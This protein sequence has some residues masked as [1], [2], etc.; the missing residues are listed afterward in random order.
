MSLNDTKN[1]LAFVNNEKYIFNKNLSNNEIKSINENIKRDNILVRDNNINNNH[2]NNIIK[3]NLNPLSNINKD[4]DLKKENKFLF[5]SPKQNKSYKKKNICSSKQINKKE[6]NESNNNSLEDIIEDKIYDTE[7][8]FFNINNN[9]FIN[10]TN[11]NLIFNNCT[12][13]ENKNMD[14]KK[15][16]Q[17]KNNNKQMINKS[18][19]KK[20]ILNINTFVNNILNNK[21]N[22]IKDNKCIQKWKYISNSYYKKILIKSILKKLI[23]NKN[24]IIKRKNDKKNKNISHESNN[25]IVTT[26]IKPVIQNLHKIP[27]Y[28]DKD[29]DNY[30]IIDFINIIKFSK[31]NYFDYMEQ[32]SERYN[33]ENDKNEKGSNSFTN[34]SFVLNNF[35]NN[36][37]FKDISAGFEKLKKLEQNMNYKN[38]LNFKIYEK[39]HG[40]IESIYEEDDESEEN[41]LNE[42]IDNKKDK[43]SYSPIKKYINNIKD[44]DIFKKTNLKFKINSP[45]KDNINIII[46]K[47]IPSIN[48]VDNW[49]KKNVSQKNNKNYKFKESILISKYKEK[50]TYDTTINNNNKNEKIISNNLNTENNSSFPFIT[51]EY[52]L[53]SYKQNDIINKKNYSNDNNSTL[54]S[55]KTSLIIPNEDLNK[56][57]DN[58]KKIKM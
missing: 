7:N 26:Q 8:I 58:K 27:N 1:K 23:E 32:L 6:D 5:L 54:K 46:P 13:T 38:A 4:N 18:I 11:S 28:N 15:I 55:N 37:I 3:S 42:R 17:I 47:N 9:I 52:N 41:K 2:Y 50:S 30:K 53:I 43:K 14:N 19:R 35:A 24:N 12:S 29:N 33:I 31:N 56:N 22:I 39:Y 45:N 48:E 40:N 20:K 34:I 49:F 36:K 51:S 16:F 44:I 25:I 10:K 57:I 21:M